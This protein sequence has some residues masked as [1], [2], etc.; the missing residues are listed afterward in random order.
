MLS[1]DAAST[2]DFGLDL[3]STTTFLPGEAFHR[4]MARLR[5]IGPLVPVLFGGAVVPLI[6]THADLDAAFRNDAELPAGPTYEHSIEP[7]QGVTF[8]SRDGDEHNMLR[9][10]STVDLRARPVMAYVEQSV[11]NIANRVIDRFA[12]RR[13]VDLVAEFTAVLP[14]AVFADK[15]GLACDLDRVPDYRDWSFG[16]LSYPMTPEPAL[17]CAA[18]LTRELQPVLAARRVSPQ[19]DLIS[20]M[21]AAEHRGR[22]LDDEEILSHVRALF[23]AGAATTFHGLGNTLYALLSHPEQ[24]QRLGHE[25]SAVADAVEEMLRWEPPLGLLPRLVPHEATVAAHTLAAGSLVLFGIA[26]ANRDPLVY[27][28]PD[29]FDPGRRPTRVLTFGFGSHH[30]PGSHLARNQLAVAV[31]VLLE[32]FPAMRL[33]DPE[34]ARPSGAVMRGP[35]TLHVTLT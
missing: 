34:G 25:P 29:R 19:H 31:R 10:L 32:R 28:D 2:H 3:M 7:C 11:P 30:C 8:E 15:V 16:I 20:A 35:A 23:A 33:V 21:V 1:A 18:A 5:S 9:T 27:E 24:M 4:E 14:F 17:Q 26:A 6:T 12:H 22:R 13:E